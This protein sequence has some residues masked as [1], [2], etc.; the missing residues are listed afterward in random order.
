MPAQQRFGRKITATTGTVVEPEQRSADRYCEPD[1]RWCGAL[2]NDKP[3]AQ[4][5]DLR[6]QGRT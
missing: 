2:P 6:M 4:E 1:S 3:V 5:Y